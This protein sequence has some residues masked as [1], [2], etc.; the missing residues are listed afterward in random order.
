MSE[1]TEALRTGV[2]GYVAKPPAT[3]D[4][5]LAMLARLRVMCIAAVDASV[6]SVRCGLHRLALFL[7]RRA[8]LRMA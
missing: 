5:V 4:D 3:S 8:Q 7:H 6:T 1:A 2:R